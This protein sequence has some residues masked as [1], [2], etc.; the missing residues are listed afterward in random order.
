MTRKLTKRQAFWLRELAR[1]TGSLGVSVQTMR[2][3][4]GGVC[5]ALVRRGFAGTVVVNRITKSFYL[6]RRGREAF[7]A[8]CGLDDAGLQRRQKARR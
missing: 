7:N 4:D 8:L 6:T 3:G 1:A 2:P 5:H